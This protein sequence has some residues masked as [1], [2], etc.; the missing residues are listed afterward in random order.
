M[1]T[2]RSFTETVVTTPTDTFPISFEYDEKYDAV[3][4]F[5]NDVAVGDLGYIVSQVNAVTLKVEPAIPE[6]IVRI[7]R[8]TNIDKMKYIFDAGALFIDQ[9]VDA[10]FRQIVHSQQEVRDG[11]IKLRGDVLPLVHGLQE[12]LQQA[13]EASEAAQ[14]AAESAQDAAKSVQGTIQSYDSVADLIAITDMVDGDVV[15]VKSYYKGLNKGG[16]IF[17]YDSTKAAINNGGTIINGWV[18]E[19]TGIVNVFMFGAKGFTDTEPNINDTVPIQ[20][21]IDVMRDVYIPEGKF[22]CNLVFNNS[23]TLRGAG[24]GTFI[25]P[26]DPNKPVMTNINRNSLGWNNDTILDL[27]IRSQGFESHNFTGTGFQFGLFP[28]QEG[29]SSVGRIVMRNVRIQGFEKGIHKVNGNIGNKYYD[30]SFEYNKYHIYG[31]G[32]QLSLGNPNAELMHCGCDYF[33]GCNFSESTTAAVAYYDTSGGSGQWVFDSCAFQFNRGF[34]WFFE[35]N[36]PNGSELFAPITSINTW[37]ESNAQDVVTIDRLDGTTT[38][39]QSK[40]RSVIGS[41][42]VFIVGTDEFHTRVGI[43][44][45]EPQHT[46]HVHDKDTPVIQLT[47]NCSGNTTSNKGALIYYNTQ[48]LYIENKQTGIVYLLNQKGRVELN[49]VGDFTSNKGKLGYGAGAGSYTTQVGSKSTKVVHNYPSGVITLHNQSLAPNES[50]T[51]ILE[52]SYITRSDGIL[53]NVARSNSGLNYLYSVVAHSIDIGQC[54]ITIKN[55]HTAALAEAV[56]LNF[57]IIAGSTAH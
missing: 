2:L 33:Y 21:A 40:V 11:F 20:R 47:S 15:N 10:D 55:T 30:C 49:S 7:E 23:F 25:Y 17:V 29:Y 6:G 52:N 4:V 22:K 35:F 5:L 50:A 44:V 32:N 51:F 56:E 53:I 34:A 9:N 48:D 36:L 42:A 1:N 12:A 26:F 37:F 39:M 46:L 24:K 45:V 18:R 31:K 3:H 8:E 13:Q 41:N 54:Y 28:A 14:E 57:N 27:E 16:G 38:T 19:L 43:G